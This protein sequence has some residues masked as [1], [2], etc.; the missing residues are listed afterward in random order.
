MS[1]TIEQI[2]Q[3]RSQIKELLR[4][5]CEK[6]TKKTGLTLDIKISTYHTA[7][8]TIQITIPNPF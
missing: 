1:L 5:E 6:F 8:T 7:K 3:E 4:I 2:K